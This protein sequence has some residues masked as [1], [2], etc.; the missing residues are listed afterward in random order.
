M[1]ESNQSC[2]HDCLYRRQEL[3][4]WFMAALAVSVGIIAGFGAVVFRGMIGLIHNLSF[5][6]TFSF[7]YDANTHTA[8]GPWGAWI[9]AVPVVGGIIVTFLVKNFAPEAKGHGVPEVIDAIYMKK[10]KIRF[11]VAGIK[12]VASAISIGTG[13]SVGREGPIV[14]IGSAFGSFVGSIIKMPVR[15]RNILIAAGAAGGIAATFNT[16]LGGLTFGIEL[17]LVSI[18][19]A[20]I[21]PVAIATVT[22][23]FIGRVYLGTMPSFYIKALVIP[24]FD[25]I[26]LEHLLL[27]IPFGILIG[28]T[29]VV[30]VKGLYMSEDFFEKLPVNDYFRHIIGMSC[31][32]LIMYL[33]LRYTGHYYVQGVGYATISDV[34]RGLITSPWLLLILSAAKLLS[35]FITLGS[36][37]SGGVFSPSLYLGATMGAFWGIFLNLMFPHLQ[38][39]P[40]IFAMAGMGG[41]ISG[42]TGAVLTA[43]VMITEM[44]HNTDFVLPLIVTV[45]AAYAVR[46]WISNESIYT[47]KLLRRGSVVPEG[48]QAAVSTSHHAVNIM[49]KEF[50]L[51]TARDIITST[52]DYSNSK[53]LTIVRDHQRIIGILHH[54]IPKDIKLDN[55]SLEN[56]LDKHYL[57]FG[58]HAKV[59]EILRL[60]KDKNMH[61]ALITSRFGSYRASNII[62]FVTEHE[63]HDLDERASIL[64]Q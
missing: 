6:G 5:L 58:A 35:T 25:R 39:N 9:I 51:A 22:A 45:A 14:Q 36:G 19:A 28:L 33:F 40:L 57:I 26:Q 16:P 41:M 54:N 29:S 4:Q 27:F 60:M 1:I 18:T 56:Y 30:F 43:I 2:D 11:I 34:L 63:L 20:T 7:D 46:K 59:P 13:G 8:A 52:A 42:A 55:K 17:M 12:S 21:F 24:N 10:G 23:A 53:K 61:Y 3:S 49:N 48:L 32:G 50:E 62:G 31:M 15:Q 64:L 44:T 38:T 47:L 37:A